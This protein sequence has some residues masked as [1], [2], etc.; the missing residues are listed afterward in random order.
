MSNLKLFYLSSFSHP[1]WFKN[2][3]KSEVFLSQQLQ[4][5]I[6]SWKIGAP[7]WY[8]QT[9]ALLWLPSYSP[10]QPDRLHFQPAKNFNF[11]CQETRKSKKKDEKL[12]YFFWI[13]WIFLFLGNFEDFFCWMLLTP[14]WVQ[15]SAGRY[16]FN[17]WKKYQ[18]S[19]F[20]WKLLKN[21]NWSILQLFCF[22]N[23]HSLASMDPNNLTELWTPKNGRCLSPVQFSH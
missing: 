16:F 21:L 18:R 15:T 19:M 17:Y 22:N 5:F 12:K 9:A 4:N 10:E 1:I 11:L 23:L 6:P 2:E 20:N 13:F 8:T 14:W 3:V 7:G